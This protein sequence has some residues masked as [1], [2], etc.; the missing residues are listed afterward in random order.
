MNIVARNI[1]TRAR[2][3][4]GSRD[5][6]T[7]ILDA[8][9][10]QSGVFSGGCMIGLEELG[11]TS[12]IDVEVGISAGACC[13]AYKQA[14][15]AVLGTSIFFEE[16]LNGFI[17]PW[18]FWKMADLGYVERTMRHAKVLDTEAI[19]GNS[20][21]LFVALTNTRGC[22]KLVDVKLAADM[23]VPIIASCGMPILF[24]RPR[25]F[26]GDAYLDGGTAMSLPVAYVAE[27]FELTDLLVVI[28][29]PD[30]KLDE[31]RPLFEKIAARYC[32]RRFSPELE[33]AFLR[34]KHF[35]NIGLAEANSGVLKNSCRVAL[36]SSSHRIPKACQDVSVLKAFAKE[37]RIK[38]REFFS[39]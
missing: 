2:K 37:G 35:F 22:G 10:A 18:R 24:N 38:T 29:E 16:N 27:R 11:L 32:L 23:I 20:S 7:G 17:N 13:L 31:E 1:V 26:D 8:G 25:S 36:I 14:H 19:R 3:L 12:G 21:K 28:N 33:E 15:Q 9:G 5:L 34:R 6:R 30:E 39:S 4:P